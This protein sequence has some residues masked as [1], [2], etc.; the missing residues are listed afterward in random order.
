MAAETGF[1]VAGVMSSRS[2]FDEAAAH[3]RGNLPGRPGAPRPGNR[4]NEA[5]A[6]GRGK[7]I[8][9]PRRYRERP[10]LQ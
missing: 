9:R 8:P 4:F 2:R 3:G 5:A 1:V 10:G 7:P 6:H